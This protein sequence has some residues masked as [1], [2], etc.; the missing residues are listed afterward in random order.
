MPHAWAHAREIPL[1]A[2][3]DRILDENLRGL[4][5]YA[6]QVEYDP[7]LETQP[8]TIRTA[9]N[10]SPDRPLIVLFTN[11]S[12]DLFVAERDFAFDGQMKW[13][14]A[15]FD[16]IR[17]H[18]ELDLVVRAHPAEIVPKFQ[19]RGRIV[20]QIE[21][22]FA[23]IPSNVRLIGPESTV[24][25]DTLRSMA[26]L[27][28]VYCSSVGMEA[29]IAGQ[30]VLICG[31][32]YYARKG[33]TINVDSPSQY[34]GLLEEHA[35]GKP[36]IPPPQSAELARRF[37]YLFKFRYGIRMGLTSDNNRATALKIHD[38]RE[39]EPGMSFPLDTACDGIL[40]RDEIL[41]PA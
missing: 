35:A 13:N 12:W 28:L 15:T 9:L 6:R 40:H 37:L 23:P 41:L 24:S 1:T 10:L 22:R 11:V 21:E 33:F 30:P 39:L 27:N 3:Q 26:S 16:F 14:A 38:L 7:V 17:R 36:L 5:A 29:V 4:P 32:P 25:S 20:E 18:P 34:D 19:T 2:E 31:N 8:A